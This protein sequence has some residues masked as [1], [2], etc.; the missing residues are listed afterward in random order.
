MKESYPGIII[1]CSDSK[2]GNAQ[3]IEDWHKQRNWSDIGYHFVILNGQIE[4]NTYLDFMDGMIESGRDIDKNGAHARGYNN[5][6]GI[7]L[8]GIDTFTDNQFRSLA[9]M[10]KWL[11]RKFHFSLDEVMGHYDVSS[12]T[13][14]NFDVTKFKEKYLS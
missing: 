2:F 11:M 3:T 12:K 10:I 6:I 1:H 4:N 14:P 13:C 7:C 5:Y 8:I 9:N